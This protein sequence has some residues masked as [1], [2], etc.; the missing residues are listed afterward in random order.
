MGVHESNLS[1]CSQGSLNTLT[2]PWN[3]AGIYFNGY[4]RSNDILELNSRLYQYLTLRKAR[5]Q[6]DI[7]FS[8]LF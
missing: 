8:S 1:C 3:G 7:A 2:L 4:S 6:R 5:I